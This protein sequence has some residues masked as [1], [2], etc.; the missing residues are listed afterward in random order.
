MGNGASTGA[1]VSSQDRAILEMKVQ[2]DKLRL[3][4][5]KVEQDADRFTQLARQALRQG[6]KDRARLLLQQKHFQE[7]NLRRVDEQLAALEQLVRLIHEDSLQELE[8]DLLDCICRIRPGPAE[9][10]LW[11]RTRQ[12]CAQRAQPTGS[13]RSD[14]PYYGRQ[15]RSSGLSSCTPCKRPRTGRR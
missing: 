2:R 5:R 3:F 6:R 8:P 13:D 11:P 12:S 1:K 14:R 9:R 7:G 15:R 10:R 4:Q